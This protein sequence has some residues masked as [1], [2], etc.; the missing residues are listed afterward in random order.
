MAKLP[1]YFKDTKNY[2]KNG[3]LWIDFKISNFGIFCLII[4]CLIRK[5]FRKKMKILKI[6]SALISVFYVSLLLG[7]IY[8]IRGILLGIKLWYITYFIKKI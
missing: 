7:I 3:K 8:I 6:I 2:F 5:L 4:D 1:F